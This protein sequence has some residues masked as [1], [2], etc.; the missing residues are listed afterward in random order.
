MKILYWNLN[1][2]PIEKLIAALAIE[3]DIDLI[4]LSEFNIRKG[5]LLELINSSDSIYRFARSEAIQGTQL[6]TR[7]ST[8]L[9]GKSYI[10]P[11]M[12][13]WSI[14]CGSPRIPELLIFTGHLPSKLRHKNQ[15]QAAL[16]SRWRATIEQVEKQ[17]GHRNSVVIGDLNMDPYDCGIISSEGFHAVMSRRVAQRGSRTVSRLERAFFYNPMWS[18]YGEHPAGPPGTYYYDSATA[19]NYYWHMFDQVLIRPGLLDYFRDESLEI[20]TKAGSD[21]LLTELGTPDKK[22]GSDH[23]PI[24]FSLDL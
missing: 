24:I 8:S 15:D 11:P 2:K 19:V 17:E 3:Q 1:K 22:K 23:L 10:E 6:L 21:N 7:S 14:R 18:K 5:R 20:L 9:I 13:G 4:L 12:Q 16:S